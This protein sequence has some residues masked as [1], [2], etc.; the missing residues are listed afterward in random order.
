MSTIL[1]PRKTYLIA[2]WLLTLIFTTISDVEDPPV[3]RHACEVTDLYKT[4]QG[5]LA[6]KKTTWVVRSPNLNFY[7]FIFFF[8]NRSLHGIDHTWHH[9]L[10]TCLLP[11]GIFCSHSEML[12]TLCEIWSGGLDSLQF[13]WKMLLHYMLMF[14]YYSSSTISLFHLSSLLSPLYVWLLLIPSPAVIP[15]PD[16]S[17]LLFPRDSS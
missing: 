13:T 12:Y 14:F 5:H 10:A 17:S 9:H 15:F 6:L 11:F 1:N 3:I 16:V 8:Q 7:L 4:Q 2:S